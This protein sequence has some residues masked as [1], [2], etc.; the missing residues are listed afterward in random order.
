MRHIIFILIAVHSSMLI[1][2]A[3]KNGDFENELEGWD[4][5]PETLLH[6]ASLN[7]DS[8]ISWQGANS[9]RIQHKQYQY[10]RAQQLNVKV[11]PHTRY[12]L[13]F[14]ARGQDIK[15][16]PTGAGALVFVG[17]G[18]QVDKTF[19]AVGP[20][21]K[22]GT[23][24]WTS[25]KYG[26]FD[27]KNQT[28]LGVTAYLHMATGTVWFDDIKL[29]EFSPDVQKFAERNI[30]KDILLK[31]MAKVNL[32]AEQI[33]DKDVIA[34]IQQMHT[35][36]DEIKIPEKLNR[37]KGL[38]LFE[39]QLDVYKLMA[40]LLRKKYPGKIL[41]FSPVDPFKRQE[42]LDFV[43]SQNKLSMKLMA[44][45][46]DIE[47]FAVNVTNTQDKSVTLKISLSGDLTS[48]PVKLRKVV[49]VETGNG[50]FIDDA[51]PLLHRISGH[52]H[53][54]IVIQPGMTQQLWFELKCPQHSR[55][56]NGDVVFSYG[57]N[58]EKMP[59]KIVVA[60]LQLP[61][62]L[63]ITTF[64]YCYLPYWGLTKTR[65]KQCVEDL[66]K[67]H[68]NACM[69]HAWGQGLPFPVF[70]E[71][72]KLHEDRMN[73]QLFD[74]MLAYSQ[75]VDTFVLLVSKIF[76]SDMAKALGGGKE[77]EI[78]SAQWKGRVELWLKAVISGLKERGID[79]DRQIWTIFDEPH[80]NSI[81]K[82]IAGIKLF[83]TIDPEL[84]IYSNF[85]TAASVDEVKKLLN[86]VDIIAPEKN[87]FTTAYFDP[88]E[89]SGKE[90]WA[91]VVQNKG[92]PPY[93]IRKFFWILAE[94]GIKGYSFWAYG[95]AAD[96]PWDPYDNARHD[97]AV[98]YDGDASEVTPSKRWEAWREG[99]EDYT[100]L[101]ML[102]E[103]HPDK[104]K[105]IIVQLH[106]GKFS[107]ETLRRD[108]ISALR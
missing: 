11:K 87:C 21:K 19:F 85:F 37:S 80:G 13:T 43:L 5:W 75:Y 97:Y 63:P 72:G 34:K 30:L 48:I 61:E 101:S 81:E 69:P 33:Y 26:P 65:I 15:I 90:C 96:S 58:I 79:Y 89:D 102:K 55:E 46:N 42:A 39:Q 57:E 66:H 45:R 3:L 56:Y 12:M 31:D 20:G 16:A 106:E 27:T 94:K 24:N 18:G 103:K 41:L 51:L 23:F 9:L 10:S 74:D 73:W 29:I 104:Y 38:P 93:D 6:G 14:S 59:V 52:N 91:Y 28:K 25:Y 40:V 68:M 53:F 2:N 95:D 64:G 22:S 107:I 76:T 4:I 71:N 54:E 17:Y 36:I 77:L 83:R 92:T 67:H 49:S 32:A 86:E 47:Q 1:G 44:L 60:D 8:A 100:L 50:I 98:I 62:K 84:R 99:I 7:S 70:D 78:M 105:K 108:I 82:A 88:I 35:E